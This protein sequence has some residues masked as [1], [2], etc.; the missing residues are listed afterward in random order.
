MENPL[1]LD[2]LIMYYIICTEHQ[3]NDKYRKLIIDSVFNLDNMR[4]IKEIFALL[5][6]SN[7]KV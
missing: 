4:D 6:K 3:I 5:T 7:Y 1:N 2:E